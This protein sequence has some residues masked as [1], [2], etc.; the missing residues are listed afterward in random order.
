MFQ[1][2][3]GGPFPVDGAACGP[4]PG[5]GEDESPPTPYH[6]RGL[7]GRGDLGYTEGMHTEKYGPVTFQY[8]SDLSGYVNIKQDTEEMAILENASVEEILGTR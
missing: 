3:F 1:P 2:G 5:V 8:N 4:A 7:T 6:G